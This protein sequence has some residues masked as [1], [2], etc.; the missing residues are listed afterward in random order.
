MIYWIWIF[1]AKMTFFCAGQEK[2]LVY[3]TKYFSYPPHI[4]SAILEFF[5]HFDLFLAVV[6]LFAYVY[7][8]ASN[9][10]AR[11]AGTT[12]FQDR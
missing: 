12:P 7:V 8:R 1:G 4:H 2:N 11:R 10:R 3:G 9:T 5:T 6:L